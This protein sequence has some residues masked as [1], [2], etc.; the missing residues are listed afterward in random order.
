M[1]NE[2]AQ[3]A[4]L[5]RDFLAESDE[6]LEQLDQDLV[7]LEAAPEDAELVNRVFRAFHTIKGTSG[8]M[9]FTQI[10]ELTHQTE[11]VLNLMRKGERKV[12]PLSMDV[13]LAV[14]D[15]LRRMLSDIRAN[16]PNAYDL[17]ELLARL[18]SLLEDRRDRPMLGEILVADGAISHAERR[19]AL[20]QSAKTGKKLGEV[21]IERQ[22]V[23]PMQISDALERQRTGSDPR[24]SART[25]RVDAAKLDELVDLVGE[26]VLERNRVS[27]LSR[28]YTEHRIPEEEFA[29]GLAQSSARLSL[30]TEELQNASLRARMVPIDVVFRRFPRMVRD[31]ARN[32]GKEVNLLLRGEDTE[33]DK[34]VVE[35]VADPLVH[36]VRNSLDHGFEDPAARQQ[37][38][39][40]RT[41][42]LLI[43]ARP[44]GDYIVVQVRD[45]GGGIDPQKLSRKAAEKG[46]FSPER[47]RAM[48][49]REL[50]D[51]I[52]LPGFST[53]ETTTDLSGRG[54]GMDVVRTNLKKLNGIVEL[55]S[56]LG[57]G[58]VVTL[59]LPLTLAI[60]PV[61]LVRVAE[62]VFALPLRSVLEILRVAPGQIH[63]TDS[64][65]VFQL[66]DR[67]VAIGR[68]DSLL[69][70][71]R[72]ANVDAASVR[73]VLLGVGERRVGVVVDDFL[74]QEETV[75]K[76]L[77]SL[78]SRTPAVSGATISGQGRV[79]LIL[80]PAGLVDVL[81]GKEP[82]RVAD[83]VA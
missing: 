54:V 42:T 33:L 67:V 60:L 4:A 45:D 40:P 16:T 2:L 64:S 72:R 17:A 1:S 7:K 3:D 76:P 83:R 25:V 39:K 73:V 19:E 78:F 5:I 34:A 12:T 69:G 37:A 52:F 46:L 32:L 43:E 24:E 11:D 61:L 81:A 56:Q 36:L 57:Q 77:G 58:T 13:F 28:D 55:E 49:R 14:L 80:D 9:G 18:R 23:S 44:E 79:R 26:L 62:E 66:R 59:K 38:G 30:V 48:S 41:G 27:Q 74:G 70:L 15:Q 68:L 35:E 51:L 65:E 71:E 63:R 29:A 50:L 47:L 31:I 8:F 75:I 22:L 10:V 6:L 20:A 82:A 53:A 21:L